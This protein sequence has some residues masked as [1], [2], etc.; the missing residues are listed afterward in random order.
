MRNSA[1]IKI[2]VFPGGNF[3]FVPISGTIAASMV[4]FAI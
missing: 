4:C 3:T 1:V 2:A